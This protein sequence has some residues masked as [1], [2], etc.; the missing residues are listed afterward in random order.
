MYRH[1]WHLC[2]CYHEACL[3]IGGPIL[4]LMTPGAVSPANAIWYVVP[5]HH[6]WNLCWCHHEPCLVICAWSHIAINDTTPGVVS[7]ANAI[8]Y[9]HSC[10][11]ALCLSRRAFRWSSRFSASSF[12]LSPSKSLSM[13]DEKLKMRRSKAMKIYANARALL[14]RKCINRVMNNELEHVL[15]RTRQTHTHTVYR[16][17]KTHSQLTSVGLARACPNYNMR[18]CDTSTNCTS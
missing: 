6:W 4:P 5:N 13:D 15:E 7:S 2:W 12:A 1:W 17:T 9:S 10:M 11:P 14:L 16:Q 3:M 18:L 8:W